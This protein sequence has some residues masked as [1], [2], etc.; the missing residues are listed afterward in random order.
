MA[1]AGGET[2]LEGRKVAVR[3]DFHGTESGTATDLSG[4]DSASPLGR[5]RRNGLVID[6]E[7]IFAQLVAFDLDELELTPR[8]KVRLLPRRRRDIVAVGAQPAFAGPEVDQYLLD[9]EGVAWLAPHYYVTGSH[10]IHDWNDGT[11]AGSDYRRSA[12]LI[13]RVGRRGKRSELSYRL[14][15]V[16][17]THKSLSRHYLKSPDHADGINIEG[18][19]AGQR[20]LYFGFRSPVAEGKALLLSVYA[21][22]LFEPGAELA[23]R[24]I[25]V[26]LGNG[27]GIRD[28]AMLPDR[29][30]LILAGPE[31]DGGSGFTLQLF[32]RRA[33]KVTR[34]GAL[35]AHGGDK[36]E[37]M[38]LASYTADPG[39]GATAQVLILS[40][41]PENGRPRLYPLN[42]PPP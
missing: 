2:E 23:P 36:P 1:E 9:G 37:A 38:L 31:P 20:R 5:R 22:A 8:R 42:L 6:N 16:L 39:G 10:S 21:A 12:F 32:D 11:G 27:A 34:L 33:G 35:P 15:E 14:N 25:R 30:L 28:L 24:L 18:L 40:D 7:G 17:S 29:R 3:G 26:A 4:I 19:A 41:G 13:A